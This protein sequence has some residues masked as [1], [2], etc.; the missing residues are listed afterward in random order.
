MRQG[1]EALVQVSSGLGL[2]EGVD[3]AGQCPVVDPPATLG[4]CDG[5]ADGQ[6]GLA[7]T[8]LA[9]D[10]WLEAE[11]EV[12]ERLHGQ[13]TSGPTPGA[14]THGKPAGAGPSILSTLASVGAEEPGPSP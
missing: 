11:I 13:A 12:R 9:L 1:L 2:L 8:L 14:L 10:R 6:G 4:R 5:K 3:E 7:I